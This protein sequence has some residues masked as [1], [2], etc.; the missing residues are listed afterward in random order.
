M[1]DIAAVTLVRGRIVRAVRVLQVTTDD[2][3]RGAQVFAVQLGDRLTEMGHDVQ[4][5]GLAKGAVRGLDIDVLGPSRFSRATLGRLRRLMTASDVVVAHGSST[6]PAT[7]FANLGTPTPLVYRQISDPLYWAPSAIKRTRVRAYY[8][9]PQHVVALSPITRD[10]LVERFGVPTER[11]TVIPNAADER[12]CPPADALARSRART[13]FGIADNRAVVG[14]VGAL[15][16]EKGVAD[17]VDA[18]P[19]EALLLVAGDGPERVHLES[20]ASSRGLD[21]CFLGRVEEPYDIFAASDVATLPSRGGDTQP[22]ALIEAALVGTPCVSTP[23]GAIGDIIQ[24]GRNGMLVPIGDVAALSAALRELIGD[25][26]LRTRLNAQARR[27]AHERFSMDA[28]SRRWA[29]LL[30]RA[31]A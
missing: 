15:V 14:Y 28:V 4:T 7:G 12:Q 16:E 30:E 6:L 2:D 8:R 17:L 21:A 19:D 9:L 1:A 10:V 23:V 22:A 3:R 11:I 25:Q 31:V 24:H 18:M 5:V 27:D 29:A 20:R 13:R 26:A